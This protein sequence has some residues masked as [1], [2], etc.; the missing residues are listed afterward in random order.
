MFRLMRERPQDEP[1]VEWLYDT[2][3]APGRTALSSYRLRD[4]V[5][6]IPELCLLARDEYDAVAGA[7]RYWPVQ[8]GEART[9]CLLLG[10]VAVHPNRQGEGLA[11]SLIGLTLETAGELGWTRVALVGDEPYY[12]RFGFTR[13]LGRGLV[14]PPPTNPAR[15]LGRELAVPG[16]W[17]GVAGEVQR[18]EGPL[19]PG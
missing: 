5:A 7:I 17:E 9:P 8:I 19:V 11:A 15:V 14:F 6:P 10:P 3:F 12:R 1:E 16:A 2:C 4:G 18:W 13:E